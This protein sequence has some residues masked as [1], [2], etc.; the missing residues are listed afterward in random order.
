MSKSSVNLSSRLCFT[1]NHN[2][3]TGQ[4]NR[5]DTAAQEVLLKLSARELANLRRY[6]SL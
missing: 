3:D 4:F 5:L 6:F 2:D 1:E